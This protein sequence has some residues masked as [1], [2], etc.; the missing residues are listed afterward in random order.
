MV[1]EANR[2]NHF[3]AL[4]G[5]GS[6]LVRDLATGQPLGPVIEAEGRGAWVPAYDPR[7]S[8][9]AVAAYDENRAES[10]TL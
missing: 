8:W 1:L 2:Y 6:V 9:T 7:G 5:S 3:I 4:D 10:L